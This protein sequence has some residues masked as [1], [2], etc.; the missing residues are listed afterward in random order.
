M[1]IRRPAVL[2]LLLLLGSL[3]ACTSNAST[4]P[5]ASGAPALHGYEAPSGAPGF[6]A[7]FADSTHLRAIPLAL[8][9]LGVD[10]DDAGA[11]QQLA[12]AIVD[13]RAVLDDVRYSVE[14]ADLET[15]VEA[16]IAALTEAA[17]GRVS[18]DLSDTVAGSLTDVAGQAQPAC[19]FPT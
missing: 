12:D 19:E 13:L 17:G 11:R 9:A 2:G 8:G 18:A 3:S 5:E 6:C 15:A 16:L 14:Y 7:L 4:P 1:I 10:V